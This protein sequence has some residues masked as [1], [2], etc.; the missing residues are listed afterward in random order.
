M[1]YLRLITSKTMVLETVAPLL[2]RKRSPDLIADPTKPVINGTAESAIGEPLN[3]VTGTCALTAVESTHEQN[4][5]RRIETSREYMRPKF[6]R[7]L[8]WGM[9]E[10]DISPTAHYSLFADP[11]PLLNLNLKILLLMKLSP[12]TLN[13]SQSPVI[14][15]LQ[16]LMCFSVITL[17][18][19][20]YSWS[21]S[22]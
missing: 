12:A 22:V 21:S 3:A 16:N 17:I 20:L 7:D 11:L 19:L 9:V 5:R 14:L 4:V 1:I 2:K 10:D 15:T 18:K 13:F 6:A 8:V